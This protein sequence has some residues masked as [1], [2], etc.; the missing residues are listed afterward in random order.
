MEESYTAEHAGRQLTV[1]AGNGSFLVA[2]L[3]LAGRDDCRR[4]YSNVSFRFDPEYGSIKFYT[5]LS[6]IGSATISNQTIMERWG[7]YYEIVDGWAKAT[8][9]SPPSS[10]DIDKIGGL[11]GWHDST[12]EAIYAAVKEMHRYVD[13]AE[14]R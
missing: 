11:T 4:A 1:Q 6:G 2:R 3:E 5:R 12:E 7:Q 10:E 14:S 8:G 13:E 9:F